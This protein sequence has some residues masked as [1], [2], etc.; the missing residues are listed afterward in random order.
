LTRAQAVDA[1]TEVWRVERRYRVE[2]RCACPILV[3]GADCILEVDRDE[4][5]TRRQ[6]LGKALGA[7][8]GHEQQALIKLQVLMHVDDDSACSRAREAFAIARVLAHRSGR[9][10]Q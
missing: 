7:I 1:D 8:A 2:R 10:G 3:A 9:K 5:G 6:C 4:V